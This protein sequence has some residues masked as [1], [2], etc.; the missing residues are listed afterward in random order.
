MASTSQFVFGAPHAGLTLHKAKKQGN[1]TQNMNTRLASP[2]RWG[3]MASF[4][5]EA[6]EGD[7]QV[8]FWRTASLP[9]PKP[10]QDFAQPCPNEATARQ[11]RRPKPT[12]HALPRRRKHYCTSAVLP[13]SQ[14]QLW[15]AKRRTIRP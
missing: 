2:P 7:W 3:G 8:S 6:A 10:G 15:T 1:N 12:S 9:R 4:L 14:N 13:C 5:L 11:P